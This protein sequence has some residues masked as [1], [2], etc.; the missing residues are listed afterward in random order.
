MIIMMKL[1]FHPANTHWLQATLHSL[2]S[3]KESD[4]PFSG[5]AIKHAMAQQSFLYMSSLMLD[6]YNML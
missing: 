2:T 4:L 1:A 3:V 5:S 6:I